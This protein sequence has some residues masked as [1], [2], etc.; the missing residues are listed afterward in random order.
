MEILRFITAGSVDDG[1]STLIGRLLYD[2]K[3]ILKD[4]LEAIE[5]TSLKDGGELNL[6]LLTDGLKAEREQGITID[7]AYK[8]FTTPKRKFIIADAPGHTQYT[9]NMITGAS[10]ANLSIILIDARK[11]VIEQTYRHSYIS[12]LVRIPHLVVCINK[13]DL[14]GFSEEIFNK[15]KND[16]NSFAAKLDIQDINFI[17]ISALKGDNVVN[18]S[19][20]MPWYEGR[21]LLHHLED[22]YIESDLNLQDSRFPVQYVIRPQIDE[23]RDF[24]G[25]AGQVSGGIFKK[26]DSVTILPAGF[27]SKISKIHTF[28]GALEEAFAP[29]S[30]TMLLEDNIDV[31][32]GNMIAK[33]DNLPEISQDITAFVCWMDTNKLTEGKKFLLRHTTNSVKCVVKNI[34]HKIDINTFE[35][36]EEDKI[37]NLNDIA[38]IS[39]RTS[40]PL[41]FDEY[42][43]N[44]LTGSFILVDEASNLTAGAG[45]IA[46]KLS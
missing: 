16:F 12:S 13:M 41:M 11:G 15:I 10:T 44:R 6:A 43:K 45:I 40:S 8:Y 39:I 28:D 32:R 18:L 42:R 29:M 30:I 5:R 33:S 4:Q 21:S 2:S 3:S 25:Y 14:V 26:G 38:K 22:V 35:N 27:Q 36:L 37:L 31:S 24:R 23:F 20:E 34:I 1:K 17:P 7:V 46:G 19:T 9:R